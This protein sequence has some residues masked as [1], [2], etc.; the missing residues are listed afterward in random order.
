MPLIIPP[1]TQFQGSLF[2]L[3][4][5]W[6]KKPVEGDRLISAEV[7]WGGYPPGQGVQF[8]LS[9]NSP[10]SFSQ[11][12]AL[13]VDNS[14]CGSDVQ[15][16]F[17]DSG[18]MLNVPS[19]CQGVFPVFSNGLSF[20]IIGLNTSASDVTCVLIHNSMPPPIAMLPTDSQSTA[21]I[22]NVV[23]SNGTF[24]IIPATV[25]GTLNGAS[26]VVN[27][28]VVSTPPQA[29]LLTLVDGRNVTIWSSVV[30]VAAPAVVS[31]PLTGINVRFFQGL[32]IRISSDTITSANLNA[33][34][35]YTVP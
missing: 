15:F 6:N 5:L 12:V 7:D 27:A 4:G 30:T 8:A 21:A 33:N 13:T 19:H 18:Y 31:V 32:S 35:Y 24:A 14:R 26:I 20:Y 29:L 17:S 25:N 1:F 3:R 9:G 11:I 10:V 23:A 16:V 34:V 28:Y 22:S 2:P